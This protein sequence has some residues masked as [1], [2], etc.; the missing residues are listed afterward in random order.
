MNKLSIEE[1]KCIQTN[2]LLDVHE[3]CVKNNIKYSI[4]YGTLIGAVR[5]K[6]YIPWDDDIDIM[7]LRDDY[8]RFVKTY[9][10]KYNVYTH[11]ICD[12]FTFAFAK[13]SDESTRLIENIKF[14]QPL[15]VNIDIFPFDNIP[16]DI[17]KRL[18]HFNQIKKLR[19]IL[20]I[21]QIKLSSSVKMSEK[22]FVVLKKVLFYIIP[23]KKIIKIIDTLAQKYRNEQTVCVANI[24]HGY[25]LK[26]VQRKDMFDDFDDLDFEGLK[27]KAICDFSTNLTNVY[28]DFMELPPLEKQVTHHNFIAFRK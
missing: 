26:E 10:S 21:K 4:A 5:H 3:F 1:I 27:F 7:M 9:V 15:G 25:G 23:Q 8:E 20:Y 2:I 13:V 14:K 24:V 16:D 22:V 28:G 18:N 19:H 11:C 17:S 6:G 12:K